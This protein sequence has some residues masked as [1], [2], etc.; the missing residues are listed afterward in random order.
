[1]DISLMDL[2]RSFCF[3]R[4]MTLLDTTY[5]RLLYCVDI[6]QMFHDLKSF[7]KFCGA[8]MATERC[9]AFMSVSHMSFQI[10]LFSVD[11]SAFTREVAY[12]VH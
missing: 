3:V 12:K 7:A 11:L 2:H 10:E 1:M 4:R 6:C 8:E 5:E 9:S